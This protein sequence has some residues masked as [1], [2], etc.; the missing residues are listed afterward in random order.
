M[1]LR[2]GSQWQSVAVSGNQWQSVAIS[3]RTRSAAARRQ[4]RLL[5]YMLRAADL[6]DAAHPFSPHLTALT[7]LPL[8]LYPSLNSLPL[9][10]F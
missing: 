8:S 4:L 1:W 10:S 3:V 7:S 6:S 2:G 5:R 9:A